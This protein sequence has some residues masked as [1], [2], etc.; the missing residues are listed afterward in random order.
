MGIALRFLGRLLFVILFVGAGIQKVQLPEKSA[1]YFG[2]QYKVYHKW[3]QTTQVFK[4]STEVVSPYFKQ[5]ISL[6]KQFTSPEFVLDHSNLIITFIGYTQLL[7]SALILLG[8]PLGGFVLYLFTF[9]SIVVIHNPF[10]NASNFHQEFM[11]CIINLAIAGIALFIASDICPK[12]YQD[13][14]EVEAAAKKV[15]KETEKVE[16]TGSKKPSQAANVSKPAEK[17]RK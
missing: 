15:Q 2:A 1:L 7:S 13:K 3:V 10:A 5:Q 8:L 4:Q 9:S 12:V 14:P 16:Q 17:K 11:N 6:V